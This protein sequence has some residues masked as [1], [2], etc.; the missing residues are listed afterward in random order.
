MAI[1][2][3]FF[4]FLGEQG[5]VVRSQWAKTWPYGSCSFNVT[6]RLTMYLVG[7]SSNYDPEP[8]YFQNINLYLMGIKIE[9]YAF[10]L[11]KGVWNLYK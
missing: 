11:H 6:G 5:L 1:S 2:F 4:L 9:E 7:A 8:L 10:Y 3:L